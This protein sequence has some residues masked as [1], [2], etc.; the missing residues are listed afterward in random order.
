MDPFT[1]ISF[2][3]PVGSQYPDALMSAGLLLEETE[4]DALGVDPG[5]LGPSEEQDFANEPRRK[6]AKPNTVEEEDDV[7]S[8]E[9]PDPVLPSID[10]GADRWAF[11]DETLLELLYSKLEIASIRFSPSY[12]NADIFFDISPKESAHSSLPGGIFTVFV[13]LKPPFPFERIVHRLRALN[14][15]DG[16]LDQALRHP[17]WRPQKMIYYIL[18]EERT[19]RSGPNEKYTGG[20]WAEAQKP[21]GGPR[22]FD[23]CGAFTR[24]KEYSSMAPWRRSKYKYAQPDWVQA[25]LGT[26]TKLI[27]E[28]HTAIGKDTQPPPPPKK[29]SAPMLGA[30]RITSRK[31]KQDSLHKKVVTKQTQGW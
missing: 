2:S 31:P 6:K 5:K 24:T 13:V 3:D 4:E 20:Y 22:G 8:R 26:D 23:Y 30:G 21:L 1:D 7:G 10:P 9:P 11:C 12:R 14:Y 29:S 25:R 17:A 19:D 27:L 16:Y 28:G 18:D 15:L